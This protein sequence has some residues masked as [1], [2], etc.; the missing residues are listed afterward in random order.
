MIDDFVGKYGNNKQY[1]LGNRSSLNYIMGID[2]R[3]STD[4]VNLHFAIHISIMRAR[5]G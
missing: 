2:R 4:D 3:E 5:H 1:Q